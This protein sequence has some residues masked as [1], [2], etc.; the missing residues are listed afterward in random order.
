[1]QTDAHRWIAAYEYGR[2]PQITNDTLY[3][4]KPYII[5]ARVTHFGLISAYHRNGVAPYL[6]GLPIVESR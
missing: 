4:M 3:Q 1:M 2:T 6:P 5:Q